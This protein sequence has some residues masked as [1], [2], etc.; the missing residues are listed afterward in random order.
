MVLPSPASQPFERFLR[1]R[2]LVALAEFCSYTGNSLVVAH[3]HALF[4]I[5]LVMVCSTI[6]SF[7]ATIM[8]SPHMGLYS[9]LMSMSLL[10]SALDGL[11]EGM[12]VNERQIIQTNNAGTKI[13]CF[14]ENGL[15]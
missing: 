15:V 14:I 10:V 12:E 13:L 6:W 3:Q 2:D 11:V 8:L 9:P 7:P 4:F 1:E 5:L